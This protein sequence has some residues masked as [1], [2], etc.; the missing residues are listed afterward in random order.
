MEWSEKAKRAIKKKLDG[1]E[2]I[3][4][5]DSDAVARLQEKVA[6]LEEFQETMV[7]AN[8]I[9]RSKKLTDDQRVERIVAE[10]GLKESTARK[11]LE[12]DDLGRI[13]FPDY[14]LTNNNSEIRRLKGRIEELQRKRAQETTEITGEK[15]HI[16]DNVED[17]RVQ[18]FFDDKPDKEFREHLTADGWHWAPSVGAW[19]KHR[20]VRALWQ[21]EELMGP[22]VET[23]QPAGEDKTP[24]PTPQPQK[25]GEKVEGKEPWQMTPAQYYTAEIQRMR[26]EHGVTKK[27]VEESYPRRP[28]DDE[29]YKLVIEAARRGERIPDNVIDALANARGDGV[30]SDILRAS[31]AKVQDEYNGYQ[32]PSARKA[33]QQRAEE[34]KSDR[35][36]AGEERQREKETKEAIQAK[37]HWQ[38]TRDEYNTVVLNN[39]SLSDIRARIE[40]ARQGVAQAKKDSRTASTPAAKKWA[41]NVTLPRAERDLASWEGVLETVAKQL[42]EHRTVVEQALKD[43]KPVPEEVLADYPDLAEKYGKGKVEQKADDESALPF[44]EAPSEDE[45]RYFGT[46][47]T[48]KPRTKAERE[49]KG[50]V[51]RVLNKGTLIGVHPVDAENPQ[52]TFRVRADQ[53]TVDRLVDNKTEEKGPEKTAEPEKPKGPPYIPAGDLIEHYKATGLTRQQAWNQYVKDTTLSKTVETETLDAKD[54]YAVYDRIPAGTAKANPKYPGGKVGGKIADSPKPLAAT[55]PTEKQKPKRITRTV[56]NQEGDVMI[57]L[58]LS[59]EVREELREG[60]LRGAIDFPQDDNSELVRGRMVP[61]P[62]TWNKRVQQYNAIDSMVGE[63]VSAASRDATSAE[64][65]REAGRKLLH[66]IYDAIFEP[67]KVMEWGSANGYPAQLEL[68]VIK[69]DDWRGLPKH[70]L[71]EANEQNISYRKPI[72]IVVIRNMGSKPESPLSGRLGKTARD[73]VLEAARGARWV[74]EAKATSKIGE[75]VLGALAEEKAAKQA[76]RERRAAE[77]RR[78]RGKLQT[79]AARKQAI[80]AEAGKGAGGKK[81][82]LTLHTTDGSKLEVEGHE[83]V[84]GYVI[85]RPADG[86]AHKKPGVTDWILTHKGTG[87]AFPFENATRDELMAFAKRLA[88]DLPEFTNV[89]DVKEAISGKWKDRLVATMKAHQDGEPF[90]PHGQPDTKERLRQKTEETLGRD[91]ESGAVGLG[92]G[93]TPD[94]QRGKKADQPEPFKYDDPEMEAV[95]ER[96]R[97]LRKD[98][99][100]A[101]AWEK[102][103]TAWNQTQREFEHLPRGQ[104]FAELRFILNFITKKGKGVASDEAAQLLRGITVK[105]DSNQ[106]DLFRRILILRDLKEEIAR[107]KGQGGEVELKIP[108]GYTEENITRNL[109]RAEEAAAAD[110]VVTEALKDRRDLMEQIVAEYTKAAKESTGFKPPLDRKEYFRHQVLAHMEVTRAP[111]GTGGEIT[112]PTKRGFLRQ[113][114]GSELDFN[115]EYLE[116]EYEVLAQMLYDTEVFKLLKFVRQKYD[117]SKQ[118]K[119]EAKQANNAGIQAV[120]AQELKDLGVQPGEQTTAESPTEA[121]MKRFKQLMGMSFGRLQKMAEEG[122]LWEGDN[123]EWAKVVK[124]LRLGTTDTEEETRVFQYLSEVADQDQP[125]SLEA[126]TILKAVSDRRAFVKKTL[127]SRYKKWQQMRGE[128]IDLWQPTPG[129]HIFQAWTLPE[130]MVNEAMEQELESIGV[131]VEKLRRIRAIGGKKLELAIPT[132]VAETLR[133]ASRTPDHGL[134]DQGV[135][136]AMRSWKVWQLIGPRRLLKYNARNLSGDAEAAFMGNPGGFKKVPKAAEDLW[137]FLIQKKAPSKELQ[138][139]LKRGGLQDNLQVAENIGN[140]SGLELF[141]NVMEEHRKKSVARTIAELPLSAVKSLWRASRMAT[142]M[143]EALLRYANYLHYQEQIQADIQA[144]GKGRPKNFGASLRDEVTAL[145]D[146]RDRAF[147]LSND[148]LGAYDEVSVFGQWLRDR[149]FPFWSFQEVNFRRQLRI[150]RNGWEDGE[151]ASLVGRSL[152]KTAIKSPIIAYRVGKFA[153]KVMAFTAMLS[154]WNHLL[155]PDEEEDLPENIKAKPHLVFGRDKD[156]KAI[157]FDRLGVFGDFLEW[158]GADESI[159]YVRAYLNGTMSLKE[160]GVDMAK[161]PLNKVANLFGGPLKS[162]VEAFAMGKSTFP[163]VTRMRR[164]RDPW[165]HLWQAYS[166]GEEYRA[167]RGRPSRGY[168]RSWGG[169]LVYK[170][171]PG[172]SA[173]WEVAELKAKFRR[174][175]GKGPGYSEGA[176]ANALYYFKQA[177]RYEDLEAANKYL[178]EYASHQGTRKDLIQSAKSMHPMWGLTKDEQQE[179]WDSLTPTDQAKMRKA[180]VFYNGFFTGTEEFLD[181][182]SKEQIAKLTEATKAAKDKK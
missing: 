140:I 6:K 174:K 115:H 158:F 169:V 121:Q 132:A 170:L 58:R 111:K 65:A 13:G 8:K 46:E 118:L 47:V 153:L 52:A 130:R 70:V 84:S 25:T 9:V 167:L 27:E 43:G 91:T 60:G 103:K 86:P 71:D 154:T 11:L 3:S 81:V 155:F 181:T 63:A 7:A 22:P 123:G 147:K 101:Q 35:R 133:K 92:R 150:F 30:L 83:V 40:S 12:K 55:K 76:E 151:F 126:A 106:Y 53:V 173:Y 134:I 116:A 20:S 80:I 36:E 105:M 64:R 18:L 61:G 66:E 14:A 48:V 24:E 21:A 135:R 56:V 96:S 67:E 45:G 97:G 161:S 113:R 85:H 148:L 44:G 39:A 162:V 33:E 34:R 114:K 157:Y 182:L 107:Q 172:E 179:F 88:H 122:E 62:M 38:V 23:E 165:E 137:V 37:E 49:Y 90:G 141:W 5:D 176:R 145:S 104:K 164:I 159:R 175:K 139:W 32:L 31:P 146:P 125:G 82:K 117:V 50:V 26:D 16:V 136:A 166:L 79:A 102:M 127:G 110:A 72:Y 98:P 42:Q 142:D 129:N 95:D 17:N 149:A 57:Q 120:I 87:M 10:L 138:E 19:Q 112:A 109:A 15:G 171:D 29:H 143:R 89:T 2:A 152:V 156:G 180:V 99:F 77:E 178:L 124:R 128:G 108:V 168:G 74:D 59:P 78:Q 73:A 68:H 4:S 177:Q 163:D 144:G 100:A 131:P 75:A 54:V 28:K 41:K 1:S 94:R 51:H 93:P 69:G 160:I 119:R